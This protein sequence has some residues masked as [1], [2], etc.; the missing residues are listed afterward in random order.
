MRGRFYPYNF[1]FTNYLIRRGGA[2]VCLKNSVGCDDLFEQGGK[3]SIVKLLGETFD[4]SR[5]IVVG[6]DSML[7]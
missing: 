4:K 5:E 1:Q 6:D 2:Q 7:L 3:V